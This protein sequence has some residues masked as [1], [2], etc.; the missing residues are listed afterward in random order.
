MDFAKRKENV[1]PVLKS[2]HK[3]F[4]DI[5]VKHNHIAA[6]EHVVC[7]LKCTL[8][9]SVTQLYELLSTWT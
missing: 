3:S 2:L 8:E 1:I 7:G 5:N 6:N 9:Q 4:S